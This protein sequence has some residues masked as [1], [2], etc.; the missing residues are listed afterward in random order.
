MQYLSLGQRSLV[1][2]LQHWSCAKRT[3]IHQLPVLLEQTGQRISR[4]MLECKSN[5]VLLTSL[6]KGVQNLLL[7]GVSFP[8]GLQPSDDCRNCGRAKSPSMLLETID[9]TPCLEDVLEL[10]AGR[11]EAYTPSL[12][13]SSDGGVKS[14]L[15]L[16]SR[17][18]RMRFSN[19]AY[20]EAMSLTVYSSCFSRWV[21]FFWYGPRFRF[22]CSGEAEG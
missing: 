10:T 2:V 14:W 7:K 4:I 21:L 3:M 5:G 8:L 6:E 15:T 19:S 13:D 17:R 1:Q 16:L 11:V 9:D 12:L 18:G 20:L 22:T